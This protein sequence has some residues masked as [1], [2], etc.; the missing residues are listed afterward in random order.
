MTT[1]CRRSLLALLVGLCAST[2][3]AAPAPGAAPTSP[4]APAP[5]RPQVDA[6]DLLTLPQLFD[7]LK[8]DSPR[9]RALQT[10]IDVARAEGRAARVLPNPVMNLAI[11]YLNSG[12][13]QNGVA[14]YYANFTLPLLVGGQRR[15]RV[16]SANAWSRAAEAE[17]LSGYHDLAHAARTLFVEL[18]AAQERVV[19]YDRAL[20]ELAALEAF[21][22]GRRQAGFESEVE[23]LRVAMAAASWQVRR[24]EAVT[25]GEELSARLAGLVGRPTWRTRAPPEVEPLGGPPGTGAVSGRGPRA[26][27]AIEAARLREAHAVQGVALARRE[28]VPV[29]ALTAGTVVIQNYYSVSTTVGVTVPIPMFDWGQG[30]R[31]RAEARSI[32]SRRER[33]AVS[34]EVEAE[35]TRGAQLLTLRRDALASYEREVL[36]KAD[37]MHALVD[38]AFRTGKAVPDDLLE[39]A[40]I[41]FDALLTHVDMKAAVMQAEVDVLAGG[42]RVGEQVR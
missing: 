21:V 11:L 36:G 27:P 32:A 10:D 16:K 2:A 37:R 30:L 39:A 22:A 40:E 17:V 38:D 42:G 15:F 13:N 26:H 23:V 24:I 41:R 33:E 35:L 8:R 1:L 34:A 3:A 28:A 25:A 4:A 9:F 12:F 14:T 29:P 19:T 20:A 5:A 6:R 7:L 18:Q 31:A